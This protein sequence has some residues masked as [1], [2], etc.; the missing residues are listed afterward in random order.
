MRRQL[1]VHRLVVG[2]GSIEHAVDVETLLRARLMYIWSAPVKV[3]R[4]VQLHRKKI[5]Q[6]RGR[7][8]GGTA[9]ETIVRGKSRDEIIGGVREERKWLQWDELTISVGECRLA[10][11]NSWRSAV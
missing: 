3:A 5:P 7:R 4:I 8:N 9:R 6:R 10:I 1:A 11:D 2:V